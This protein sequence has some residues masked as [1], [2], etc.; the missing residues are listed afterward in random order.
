MF[1]SKSRY[2]KLTPYLVRDA[3]GRQVAVVPVP[4]APRQGLLGLH[5][6]RQGER[7]DHLAAHYLDDPAGFWRIAERNDAML[8]EA[9]SEAPEIEI[10]EKTR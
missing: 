4:P 1:E 3:R 10:P 2:V 7:L 5:V 6:L 8:P 9:L